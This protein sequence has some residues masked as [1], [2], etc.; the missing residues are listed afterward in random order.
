MTRLLRH[1][2]IGHGSIMYRP[3]MDAVQVPRQWDL[4]WVL[5]A[6][7]M[8]LAGGAVVWVLW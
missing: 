2:Q 1:G 8:A 5:I 3:H 6:L 7:C 4:R